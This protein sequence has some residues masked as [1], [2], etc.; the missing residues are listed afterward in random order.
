MTRISEKQRQ[1]ILFFFSKGNS[2]HELAEAY[3]VPE[4]TIEAIIRKALGNIGGADERTT[5]RGA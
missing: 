2:M 1:I 5:P 3:R 4:P